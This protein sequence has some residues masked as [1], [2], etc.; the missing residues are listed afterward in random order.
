M[1]IQSSTKSQEGTLEITAVFCGGGASEQQEAL[2]EVFPSI[3][4]FRRNN[5]DIKVASL[6]E[7]EEETDWENCDTTT[8]FSN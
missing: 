6:A 1:T 7:G 4:L 8:N 2:A 3:L 5:S